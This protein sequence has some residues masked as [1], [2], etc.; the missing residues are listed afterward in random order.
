MLDTGIDIVHSK[1]LK[2]TDG[3]IH[4]Q[5]VCYWVYQDYLDRSLPDSALWWKNETFQRHHANGVY[6]NPAAPINAYWREIDTLLNAFTTLDLDYV[7]LHIYEPLNG[8]GDGV[9]V[10]A[11]SIKI[12]D[13]YIFRTHRQALHHQRKRAA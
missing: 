11:N 7:N 12:M 6:A 8:A 3:G 9:H 13:D 5:G 4:P 1:G 2:V 10:T